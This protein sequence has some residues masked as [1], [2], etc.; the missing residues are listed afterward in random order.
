MRL[1]LYE[2]YLLDSAGIQLDE[3]IIEGKFYAYA[4][5]GIEYSVQVRVHCTESGIFPAENMRVGL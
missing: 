4:P 5:P 1:G 2:V 3:K